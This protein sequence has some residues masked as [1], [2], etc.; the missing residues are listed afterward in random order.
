MIVINMRAEVGVLTMKWITSGASASPGD[1]TR[2]IRASHLCPIMDPRD[3][4]H[5][6]HDRA[7]PAL[8]W[9][10]CAAPGGQP[11]DT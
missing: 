7:G 6:G 11:S 9:A 4:Q 3:E 2:S 8:R 5:A 10:D 1:A